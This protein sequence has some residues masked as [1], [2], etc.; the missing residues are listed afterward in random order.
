MSGFW[1]RSKEPGVSMDPE[2]RIV[3]IAEALGR[4]RSGVLS[5]LEAAEV[6][7]MSER[8]FRRLRDRYE[9]EGAEGLVDRR[10]GR[11]SARAAP[12]D[13]IDWVLELYRTRYWD[14]TAKHFHEHL[15]R[16]HGFGLGYTW[17][18]TQLQGA[19]LVKRAKR[20]GAH[21]K[22]RPRRP[23][24]GMRLFQDGSPHRWPVDLWRDLDLIATLDDATGELVSAF[25]VEEEGT[26]SSF[27]GLQETIE[28]KGLFCAFYTDRGS[29]YFHTPKAGG[30]VD[31]G[32][33][34]QVGRALGQLGIEHIP[35]YS[36][37]ARGRIERLFGTLQGRL[38]Q[39]LR[40]AGITSIEAANRFIAETFLP[41]FNDRFSVPAAEEGSAFLPYVG[42]ALADILAIQEERQ[43]Q[44][45]NTV[46]Y[47]RLTLQIPEQAHRR[48]FVKA[49]VK[50][51]EYPDAK[52]AIFHG[53][54]CLAR[55][56]SKGDL[57]Q[58]LKQRSEER[59][60]GKECRSRWSPY[61]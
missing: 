7:G 59:R 52:L 49:T 34:T 14:F 42:R 23:L 57:L 55:Y 48:H 1:K 47:K 21:R 36:P 43:V 37:E 13:Q 16:D 60:V 32:R 20:R 54:R 25:L 5:C 17:T 19:G 58:Q 33:L 61:H 35:S 51:H 28:K 2:I 29:H 44:N 8:H 27:R 6:L 15:V 26:L 53:P 45:D 3:R 9:A 22:K 39:E 38:P 31:K 41:A 4:Y 10:L 30:K 56:D 50:V 12:L 11:A 18:K 40:L 46:R 24:P